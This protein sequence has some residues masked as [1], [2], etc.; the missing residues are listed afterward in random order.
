MPGWRRGAPTHS[1]F[2][3]QDIWW[4]LPGQEARETMSKA[5]ESRAELPA[6]SL[7]RNGN[8]NYGY[9]IWSHFVPWQHFLILDTT[10]G[11]ESRLGK[12][13]GLWLEDKEL[14]ELLKVMCGWRAKIRHFK[15]I[16]KTWLVFSRTFLISKAAWSKKLKN[17]TKLLKS[18]ENLNAVSQLKALDVLIWDRDKPEVY[19]ILSENANPSWV[20]LCPNLLQVLHFITLRA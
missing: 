17:V 13:R 20:I 8:H 1:H 2:P 12:G 5:S 7:F 11:R 16:K 18:R 9:K 6:G 10:R 19:Y 15:E 3:H 4:S 14:T